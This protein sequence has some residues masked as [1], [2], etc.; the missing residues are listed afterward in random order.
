MRVR[1][2]ALRRC[3]RR[4]RRW[5][6]RRERGC[7]ALRP[8]S[9]VSRRGFI[10]LR[11]HEFTAGGGSGV[12]T[13]RRCEPSPSSRLCAQSCLRAAG[14]K[15][16]TRPSSKRQTRRRPHLLRMRQIVRL[17]RRSRERRSTA[18][19]SRSRT[20]AGGRC[21]STCGRPGEAR[22]RARRSPM[23]SFS[24]SIP[25]S[26]TSGSTSPIHLTR[27]ASFWRS[28]GGRGRRSRILSVTVPGRSARTISRT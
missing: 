4:R 8:V 2:S 16:P 21:S 10:P 24:R 5:R 1:S 26:P 6:G 13:V 27:R 7:G 18:S 15:R 23:P 19:R 20:T 3:R 22:V 14:V 11:K 17:P 25:S 28:T 9:T 12:A